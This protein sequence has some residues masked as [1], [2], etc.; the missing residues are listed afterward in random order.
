MATIYYAETGEYCTQGLQG[1]DVCDEAWQTA[2][3]IAADNPEREY[4]LEDDD[5]VYLFSGD[6]HRRIGDAGEEW[7][8]SGLACAPRASSDAD[9]DD[10]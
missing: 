3:R 2:E 7:T 9:D 5:G 6:S 10:E 8:G 4:V 1:S